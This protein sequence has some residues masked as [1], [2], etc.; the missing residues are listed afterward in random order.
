[1]KNKEKYL[2]KNTTKE[3]RKKLLDGALTISTLDCK[4]PSDEDMELF[5]KYIDGAMEINEVQQALIKKY[6]CTLRS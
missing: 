1:M 4:V 2:I 6:S 5:Q 3:Q